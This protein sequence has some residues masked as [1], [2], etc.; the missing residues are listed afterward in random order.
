MTI[1]ITN[2]QSCNKITPKREGVEETT[3]RKK[4]MQMLLFSLYKSR[5]RR[6]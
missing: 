2:P 3:K 4:L 1:K 5:R 6:K